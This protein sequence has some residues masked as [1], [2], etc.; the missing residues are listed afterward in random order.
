MEAK[1]ISNTYYIYNGENGSHCRYSV[2]KPEGGMAECHAIIE[3]EARGD[4]FEAQALRL[5]AAEA[6]LQGR[7]ELQG[8]QCVCKRYF[9]SDPANQQHLL[10][11]EARCSISYIGQPP[12]SGSKVAVWI[13]MV[14]KEAEVVYNADRLGSTIVRH[15][16]YTH[17]WTMGMT[18]EG[19]D[20]YVQTNRLIQDYNGLLSLPYK[21]SMERNCL[22]TWFFV[23]DVDTNY[24]GLVVARKALFEQMGMDASTHYIASTG[25][26]GCPAD[27]AALVQMGAHSWFSDNGKDM[28]ESTTYLY[29]P[30]HLNRTSEYG[31][32]F[33]RGTAIDLGDRRLAYIS[34]TASINNRGEVVHEGD[35]EAQTRRMWENVEALLRECDMDFVDVMQMIVYLRDIAD[36]A[37]VKGMFEA[38]FPNVPYII[39]LAPVCRPAWLIE[40]ECVGIKNI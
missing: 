10:K 20:S 6:E 36:Y 16:G 35:I 26:G 24:R 28:T 23:R 12:L 21:G 17:L 2:F 8:T 3:V 11:D 18:C 38:R 27:R 39:T 9:L 1:S 29:A 40:M 30:T 34:G 19:A 7:E 5:R 22:R 32:T 4:S 13:Y 31:V 25:I 15:N 33:E 37:T 14:G